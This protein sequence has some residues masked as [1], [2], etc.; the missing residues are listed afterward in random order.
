M[1]QLN[2]AFGK[3]RNL[4][5]GCFLN[6]NKYMC[7]ETLPFYDVVQSFS[8]IA[9]LV[10]NLPAMQETPVWFLDREDPLEKDRLPIPV[11]LSFPC[12]SVGKES[13]CNVGDLGSIPALGRSPGKGK[14]YSFQ[15][16]GLENFMDYSSWGSQRVGHDWVTFP[17]QSLLTLKAPILLSR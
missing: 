14:G 3:K 17:F 10:K 12:G 9:Q 6:K 7:Y 13:T 15:Y 16:S 1:N 11:F 5:G 8:L 4:N 2:T